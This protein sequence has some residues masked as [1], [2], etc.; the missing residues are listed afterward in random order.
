[1]TQKQRAFVREYLV[2]L[3]ATQAALRAGYS[4]K[5]AGAIGTENL[6]KPIIEEEI[7]KAIDERA[8][9]VQISADQVLAE[10]AALATSDIMRNYVLDPDTGEVTLTDAAPRSATRAVSSVEISTYTSEDGSGRVQTKLKLWDKPRA[11]QLLAR[12]LGLL[13][14]A[15]RSDVTI[16][17][18][19]AV[20][21]GGDEPR[22]LS[23][24]EEKEESAVGK[25]KVNAFE[26]PPEPNVSS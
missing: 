25:A 19:M 8:K 17:Q 2:D 1:M 24:D 22:E 18:Y 6:R 3:N 20:K 10:L 5:T 9:R 23:S 21:P 4:K 7:K 11:L 13:I 16:H 12:H 14:E 15:P 26:V